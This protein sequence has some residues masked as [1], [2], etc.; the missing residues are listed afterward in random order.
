MIKLKDLVKTLDITLRIR[1]NF[2]ETI[3]NYVDDL[4]SEII[5]DKLCNLDVDEF[6]KQYGENY[7]NFIKSYFNCDEV[8][9]EIDVIN[10]KEFE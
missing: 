1:F 2:Y 6:I 10:K 4:V 5:C 3:R 7:V 8:T 9:I